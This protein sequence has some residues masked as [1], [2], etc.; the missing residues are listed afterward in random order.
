M[1]TYSVVS[2]LIGTMLSKISANNGTSREEE[3][4]NE[5]FQEPARV[6]MP[7]PAT[8]DAPMKS[9]LSAPRHQD[10]S[11]LSRGSATDGAAS[12]E[13]DFQC[14]ICP[15]GSRWVK[16]SMLYDHFRGHHNITKPG[17]VERLIMRGA[18]I[19]SEG[20]IPKNNAGKIDTR[21]GSEE[22]TQR[23]NKRTNSIAPSY[24]SF[25]RI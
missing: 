24:K 10:E 1:S 3:R 21:Q 20:N 22:L 19:S 18:A 5:M 11:Q 14:I 25:H 8:E 7:P 13:E 15:K 9:G 12:G 17:A 4:P 2:F 16:K 6:F 23:P